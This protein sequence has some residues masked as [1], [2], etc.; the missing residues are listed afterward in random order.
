MLYDGS[1]CKADGIMILVSGCRAVSSAADSEIDC[2]VA[3]SCKLICTSITAHSRQCLLLTILLRSP[4]RY[5]RA[6]Q[7]LCQLG[8]ILH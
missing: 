7:K 2:C 1:T 4:D 8:R 6:P 5:S 3:Y